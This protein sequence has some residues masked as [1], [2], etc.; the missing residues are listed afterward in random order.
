MN[1]HLPMRYLR[2]SLMG[3]TLIASA[4]HAAAN[5]GKVQ[6]V[7]SFTIV[8]DI[9]EQVGGDR[10]DVYNIIKSGN[11]PHEWDP[12]PRDTKKTADADAVF[13]FGWNLEGIEG[14]SAR[15]NW[16]RKLLRSVDKDP[17]AVFTLSD[18]IEQKKIGIVEKNK[19]KVNPHAFTSPRAGL[20]MTRN[21]RDALIQV[22]PEHAEDYKANA[23]ALSDE[24]KSLD[25]AYQRELQA[26][27]EENRVLFT[28]ERAFQYLAED[29]GLEEGF[30][31]EI[32]G[33]DEGTPAQIKRAIRFVKEHNPPSLFYEY[34]DDERPMNT[35]ADATGVEV[36]GTLISDDIGEADSYVD[37]LKHNLET[38]VDGL[39][40]SGS[41]SVE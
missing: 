9:V 26:L 4:G 17:D 38:I 37:Y 20:I 8:S 41:S 33:S 39:S 23:A 11:D 5:E 13:Y 21:A 10:V 34:N 27:P 31:W 6:A 7:G 29:Y 19:G 36:S 24:L 25:Q 12:S 2:L 3:L 18:G 14:D 15:Y 28:G 30:I 35:V 22:D 40:S 16:V 32:D 1:V